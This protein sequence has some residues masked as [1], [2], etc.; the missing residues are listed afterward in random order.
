ME[1]VNGVVLEIGQEVY[2]LQ[3]PIIGE[4]RFVLGVITGIHKTKVS[5][6]GLFTEKYV[7][8]FVKKVVNRYPNQ[9]IVK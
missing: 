2:V 5:V 8:G 3:T 4:H 1:S 7:R 6:E 9:I